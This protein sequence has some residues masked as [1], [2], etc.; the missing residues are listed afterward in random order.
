M[1]HHRRLRTLEP[2][3]GFRCR[4]ARGVVLGQR[5]GDEAT[6]LY[7]AMDG[8]AAQVVWWSREIVVTELAIRPIH[9]P[10]ELLDRHRGQ[11]KEKVG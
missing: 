3:A 1:N 8:Q 2:G 5:P 6:L 10:Q 4:S 11:G 9:V 7:A